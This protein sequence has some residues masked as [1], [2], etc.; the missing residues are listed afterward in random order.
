VRSM[1]VRVRLFRICFVT[2]LLRTLLL[3]VPLT[4]AVCA[5]DLRGE[6]YCGAGGFV[7]DGDATVGARATMTATLRSR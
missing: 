7:V 5:A 3:R 6:I 1:K 2:C 4:Y